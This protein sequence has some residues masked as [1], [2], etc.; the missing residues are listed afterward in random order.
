MKTASRIAAMDAMIAT[1]GLVTLALGIATGNLPVALTAAPLFCGA[2][3][4]ATVAELREVE[5]R[6]EAACRL[7]QMEA[8]IEQAT[9]WGSTHT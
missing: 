7:R 4:L 1:A 9:L 5:A 2:G 3:L 6:G 8:A